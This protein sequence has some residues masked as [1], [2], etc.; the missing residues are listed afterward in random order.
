M[1]KQLG[2]TLIELMIA[3]AVIAILTAIVLPSY[4]RYAERARAT[5]VVNTIAPAK[6]RVDDAFGANGTLGCTDSVGLAIPNCTG[7]GILSASADGVTV[8]MTP[9]ALAGAGQTLVWA[10]VFTPA[11]TP[12]VKGCGL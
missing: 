2:V 8:T 12:K 6:I 10:C 9:T 11:S 1:R 5:S 4:S 3:V 7:A